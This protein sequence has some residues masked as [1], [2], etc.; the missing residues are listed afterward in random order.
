[1]PNVAQGF[2]SY[3]GFGVQTVALTTPA[4][5]TAFQQF[6]SESIKENKKGYSTVPSIRFSRDSVLIQKGQR[7]VSGS[8]TYPLIPDEAGAGL[9]FAMLMGNNNTVSTTDT[10]AYTHVFNQL[11]ETTPADKPAY[12]ATIHTL[13]GSFD[14]TLLMQY[15]G[16]F[17]NKLSIGVKGDGGIIEATA[18]FVGAKEALSAPTIDT[19]NNSTKA[20][21]EGFHA[22]ISYGADLGTLAQLSQFQDLTVSI[23]NNLKMLQTNGGQYPFA[24]NYGGFDSTLDFTMYLLEDLTLYNYFKNQVP[25]AV[26]L[27]ITSDQLAGATTAYNSIQIDLPKCI[28]LGDVPNVSNM[29]AIPHKV[30]LQALRGTGSYQ[31]TAKVTVVNTQSGVY[32]V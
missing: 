15:I 25:L 27:K 13:R 14:N 28:M 29:E 11:R 1:M 5:P 32:S 31:Y 24:V 10:T 12:G 23:N 21:F 19:P 4:T 30:T 18:D 9:L 20:P 2:N 16:C 8:I 22:V 17:L 7:D 3:A 6:S 26:R